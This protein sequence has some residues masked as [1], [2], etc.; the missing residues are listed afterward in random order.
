MGG[1]EKKL[2]KKGFL[3]KAPDEIIEKVRDKVDLLKAKLEKLE[4]NLSFFE[5]IND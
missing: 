5:E 1:S 2:S 4:G 3:E